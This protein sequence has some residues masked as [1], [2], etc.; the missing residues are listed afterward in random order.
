ME[1]IDMQLCEINKIERNK[2]PSSSILNVM[3]L[4][5]LNSN[6]NNDKTEFMFSMILY[7]GKSCQKYFNNL[8]DDEILFLGKTNLLDD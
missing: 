5:S 7:G 8:L 6:V 1:I 2:I 3:K 4:I